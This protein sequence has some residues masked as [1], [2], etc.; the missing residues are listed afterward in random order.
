[1]YD[2]NL[3][4][5]FCN[6]GSCYRALGHYGE[7]KNQYKRAIQI[8]NDDAISHYNLANIERIIGNY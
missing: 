5:A 4:Q 1:M 2:P 3:F 8:K 7:A 6:M